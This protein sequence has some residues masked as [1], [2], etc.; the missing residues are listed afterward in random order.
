MP[1]FSFE[2]VGNFEKTDRF[3]KRMSRDEIFK[4]LD[5]YGA[6]GVSAL[7]AATPKDSGETAQGWSYEIERRGRSYTIHWVNHHVNQGVNIAAIIQLGHGTR[8]G[9]YVQGI[10]YINPALRPIFEEIAND[11]WREVTK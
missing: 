1:S 7:V 11:V 8:N 3:L 6:K 10:D 9:G 2:S 4:V 5:S